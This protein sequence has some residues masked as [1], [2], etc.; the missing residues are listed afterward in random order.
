MN[1]KANPKQIIF[2]LTFVLTSAWVVWNMPGYLVAAGVADEKLIVAFASAGL[3]DYAILA[4]A[5]ASFVLG[6]RTVKGAVAEIPASS[7]MDRISIFL[8]RTTMVLILIL[9]AVM[10]YEVTLRYAFEAPTLWANELSLWIAGIVFLVSGVYAQQQRK[11]IRIDIVYLQ[12][13]DWGRRLCDG[14]TVA[15][16]FA[17]GFAL[18]WGSYNEVFRKVTR[19]ET[20]GTAFDPPIPATLMPLLIAVV[21]LMAFQGL[22][23][24]LAPDS[25]P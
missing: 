10:I 12:L 5:L 25:D 16:I 1:A 22:A 21:F 11:H 17:F 15:M 7:L 18:L 4:L 6:V 19:W 23:N 9:L 8:G 13:P 14:L 2:P 24:F 3:V 20:F